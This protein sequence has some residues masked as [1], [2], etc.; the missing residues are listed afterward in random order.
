MNRPKFL[1]VEGHFSSAH[2]L[3]DYEGKCANMHGHRWIVEVTFGPFLGKDPLGMACD[4]HKL[5]DEINVVCDR[6]DHQTLNDFVERPTA[7]NLVD[8]F[9]DELERGCPHP[10]QSVKLFESPG[11]A[12]TGIADPE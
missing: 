3:P 8:Y 1:T 11:A 7:E 4:F 2:Y 6:L 12:C 9:F 5:K 10:V